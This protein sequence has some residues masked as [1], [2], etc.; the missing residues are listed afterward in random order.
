MHQAACIFSEVKSGATQVHQAS[1][2][3]S[4]VKNGEANAKLRTP[5]VSEAPGTRI[6]TSKRARGHTKN[7]TRHWGIAIYGTTG[8]S[9]AL[10]RGQMQAP[11]LDTLK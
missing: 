9:S 5:L 6:Q 4:K 7:H 2:I 11:C 10:A 8:Y 3:F 1:R